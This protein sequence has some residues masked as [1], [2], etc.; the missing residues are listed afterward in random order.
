[1]RGIYALSAALAIAI[2]FVV[3]LRVWYSESALTS[4]AVAAYARG[5]HEAFLRHDV[6]YTFR[7]AL[8]F[9]N[10]CYIASGLSDLSC[11]S[12]YL[13]AWSSAWAKDGIYVNFDLNAIQP[14]VDGNYVFAV[15]TSPIKYRGA[16]SGTIPPGVGVR[17][18]IGG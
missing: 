13:A 15:P 7:Q 12:H 5:Q 18:W 1:M 4:S 6:E 17:S 9:A 3:G 8:A 14:V 11:Y 10:A 16:V 2:L